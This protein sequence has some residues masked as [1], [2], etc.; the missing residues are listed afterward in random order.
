MSVVEERKIASAFYKLVQT[1]M[2]FSQAT[3]AQYVRVYKRF[4]DSKHRS[5]VE[6]LFT[7]GDLALLVP[8]PDD[9]LDNVVSAKEANPG[10]TRN[11]LKQRLGA[12]KAGELVL[13][14][15]PE[16]SPPRP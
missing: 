2:G 12:R 4:A 15:R 10:M 9:E 1:E 3:T 6:A 14:C 7:A 5:Q 11:Q 8:F 13:D 16:H